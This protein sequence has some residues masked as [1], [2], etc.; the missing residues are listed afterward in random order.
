MEGRDDIGRRAVLRRTD[1]N[2]CCGYC[3][4]PSDTW[5]ETDLAGNG[6]EGDDVKEGGVPMGYGNHCCEGHYYEMSMRGC[7]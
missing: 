7:R 5:C 6:K 4:P 2:F 3:D 1:V